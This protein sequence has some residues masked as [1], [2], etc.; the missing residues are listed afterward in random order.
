M[1]WLQ[2]VSDVTRD[3]PTLPAEPVVDTYDWDAA[4]NL[5]I[6]GFFHSRSCP[7][8]AD[9]AVAVCE[10]ERVVRSK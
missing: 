1:G 4:F 3:K 6:P 10:A 5:K 9:P 7:H 2:S 8:L